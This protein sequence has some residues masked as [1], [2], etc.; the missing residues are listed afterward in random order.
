METSIGCIGDSSCWWKFPGVLPAVHPELSSRQR[1]GHEVR[2]KRE[3]GP[4]TLV[5][6]QEEEQLQLVYRHASRLAKEL[7]RQ[8]GSSGV[9]LRGRCREAQGHC[10]VLNPKQQKAV[11]CGA[12]GQPTGQHCPSGLQIGS[13][14]QRVA[15]GA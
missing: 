15:V 9:H 6:Q 5:Q 4:S 3:K 14:V 12:P 13:A 2:Q 11:S 10:R 7:L 8:S 1:A